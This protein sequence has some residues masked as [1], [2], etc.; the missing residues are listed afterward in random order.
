MRKTCN[1]EVNVYNLLGE[2]QVS[3]DSQRQCADYFDSDHQSVWASLNGTG[4]HKGFIIKYSDGTYD[5]IEPQV[6]FKT[7]TEYL[8]YNRDE[9]LMSF[10]NMTEISQDLGCTPELVRYS[11][12]KGKWICKK[13]YRIEKRVKKIPT[14]R[15]KYIN[16]Y[17]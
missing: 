4:Y 17:E 7:K 3:F 11:V 15:I 16:V 9:L 6:Q 1:T 2:Y 10:D 12:E 8:L 14:K 5:N 13:L